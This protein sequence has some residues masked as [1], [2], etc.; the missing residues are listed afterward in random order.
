L[1]VTGLVV[2]DLF[3]LFICSFETRDSPAED[4]K[5]RTGSR[6]RSDESSED[7]VEHGVDRHMTGGIVFANRR[8]ARSSRR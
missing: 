1:S 5:M 7:E 6:W 2:I 8:R 4:S 3:S